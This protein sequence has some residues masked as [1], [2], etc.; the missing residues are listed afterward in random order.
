VSVFTAEIR[1]NGLSKQPVANKEANTSY[2]STITSART[3]N[4]VGIQTKS[5]PRMKERP[6]CQFIQSLMV[7]L[8]DGKQLTLMRRPSMTSYKMANTVKVD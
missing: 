3:I 2:V 1:C 8:L 4:S 6:A 5:I 7:P